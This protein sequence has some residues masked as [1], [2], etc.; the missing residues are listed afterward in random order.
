MRDL[1]EIC[2]FAIKGHDVQKIKKTFQKPTFRNILN[3]ILVILEC[4]TDMQLFV[5]QIK[6]NYILY[7]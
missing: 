2:S 1:S 4:F 7:F 5:L 6:H 3:H